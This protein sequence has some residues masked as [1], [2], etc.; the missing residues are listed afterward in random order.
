MWVEDMEMLH[1][2]FCWRNRKQVRGAVDG[3]DTK[4]NGLCSIVETT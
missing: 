1:T 2:A 4:P 3:T